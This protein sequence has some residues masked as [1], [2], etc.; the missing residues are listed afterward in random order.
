MVEGHGGGRDVTRQVWGW[1]RRTGSMD[2]PLLH[3]SGL[4]LQLPQV[5]P[6]VAV[7]DGERHLPTEC[8]STSTPT[9]RRFPEMTVDLPLQRNS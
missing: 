6:A 3:G 9:L 5:P 7:G 1:Y 8:P 4:H 2:V